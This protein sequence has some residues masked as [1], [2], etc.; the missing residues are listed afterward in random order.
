MKIAVYTIAL[1]EERHVER[2]AESCADADVRLILDTGSTD[3]TVELAR[4]AGVSVHERTFSPFRFDQA[5][6]AAMDLIPEDVDLCLTLDMDEV[7]M[8]DWRAAIESLPANVTKPRFKYVFSRNPDGSEGLTF[9]THSSHHRHGYRWAGSIH[10]AVVR[11]PAAGPEV[12]GFCDAVVEN[13]PDLN[14]PRTQYLDMLAEATAN[15]PGEPRYAFYFGRELM[16][17]GMNE[18]AVAEL[19]RYL[20]LGGDHY[21]ERATALRY[22][23]AMDLAH[24]EQHLLRACAEAPRRRE[25]W[26]DLALLHYQREAWE[27]CLAAATRALSIIERPLGYFCEPHAWGASPHDLAALSSHNLGLHDTA[28]H[29]GEIALALDPGDERLAT[30]L[31]FY[32]QR[33]VAA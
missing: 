9:A 2:W 21:A 20:D 3:R 30:N 24:A 13:L 14:K 33:E 31:T 22:L 5:R 12:Q 23:A 27:E 1:N 11:D 18:E 32:A 19:K 25:P 29:H 28:V 10:E 6:N 16:Y 26:V 15:E 7:L 17:R 8:P 4:A